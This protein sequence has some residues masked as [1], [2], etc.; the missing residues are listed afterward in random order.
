MQK[1]SRV[2]IGLMITSLITATLAYHAIAQDV[3]PANT[4]ADIIDRVMALVGQGRIDDAMNIMDDLKNQPDLNQAIRGQLIDLRSQQLQ[5]HSYD[6]A[7]VQKFTGN[8]QKFDV[9]ANYEQQPIL[10]RFTF[11]RP[12]AGGDG[13]WTVHY[14]GVH[15]SVVD[16]MEILKDSPVEYPRTGGG[17]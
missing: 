9:I 17:R 3:A 13:K 12:R 1:K 5:Y 4:P 14:L 10:F 15:P 7:A 16:V 2:I 6:I 8:F 11:Y